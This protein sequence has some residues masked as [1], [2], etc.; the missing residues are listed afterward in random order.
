[1]KKLVLIFALMIS[2]CANMKA[3]FYGGFGADD[4]D[5]WFDTEIYFYCQNNMV[6]YNMWGYQYGV[7]LTNV[8]L[9]INGQYRVDID[10]WWNYGDWIFLT[11]GAGYEFDKGSTVALYVNGYYQG[12]WTCTSS[13]PTVVDAVLRAKREHRYLFKMGTSTVGKLL[14]VLRKV[15]L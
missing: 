2:F 4:P 9:I 8:Q 3:Q 10:G 12:S 14:K 1:M 11:K 7:N 6:N 13:N 5:A 15:R